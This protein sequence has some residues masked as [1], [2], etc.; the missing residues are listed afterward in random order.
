MTHP[1]TGSARPLPTRAQD[2]PAAFA[3]RFNHGDPQAVQELYEAEAAFVSESGV[4]VHG[5]AAIARQNAPFLGLGLPI[6]V[7]PRRVHVAGDIA[8]L[9]VDWEIT[10]KVSG[11]A[12][13]VVR[14]GADGYWRY[15]VDSPFGGV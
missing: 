3:D 14:R 13:D 15:V 5:T 1:S 8:L 9:I 12:T 7:R 11:T 10:G 6:S 2:V 4:T